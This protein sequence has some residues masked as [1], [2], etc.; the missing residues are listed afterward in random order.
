MNNFWTW[1]ISI[2]VILAVTGSF[3]RGSSGGTPSSGFYDN[4]SYSSDSEKSIDRQDAIDEYWDDIRQYLSGSETVEAC[5]SESGGCYDLDADISD[6]S[7]EQIYFTNG[8]YLYFSADIDSDG[9][10][11]DSDQNGNNWDFTLDMDSSIVDDAVSEWADD[12][13]YTIQ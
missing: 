12:N 5:S 2:A 11:S 3:N 4:S 10:A 7:V 6:G 8:G 1:A 9:S 13:G